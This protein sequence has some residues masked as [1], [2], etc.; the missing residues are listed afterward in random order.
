MPCFFLL[1]ELCMNAQK[2]STY[3]SP[4]AI[5]QKLA[6]SDAAKSGKRSPK[7]SHRHIELCLIGAEEIVGKAS[8]N[9]LLICCML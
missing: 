7:A 4:P 6:P 9:Y 8:T 2:I 1:R 5:R 3:K